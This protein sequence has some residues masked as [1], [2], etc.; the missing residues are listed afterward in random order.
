MA[1]SS[2]DGRIYKPQKLLLL[3]NKQ[4]ELE[5]FREKKKPE[6]KIGRNRRKNRTS[7]KG[8]PERDNFGTGGKRNIER[9]EGGDHATEESVKK[10]K[11][12]MKP[13]FAED[14]NAGKTE[15]T[16]HKIFT[17]DETVREGGETNK[18]GRGMG[19]KRKAMEN[20][21]RG[22]YNQE[23]LRSDQRNAL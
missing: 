14:S 11:S 6:V 17:I 20:R 9:G 22:V 18:E 10:R 21:F 13:S 15:R 19:K 4:V 2:V 23:G 7:Q 16:A 12:S 8:V 5:L 1:G 3:R